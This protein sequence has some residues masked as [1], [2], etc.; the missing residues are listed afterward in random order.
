MKPKNDL[1]AESVDV[2]TIAPEEL[3][4][5]VEDESA[6][7]INSFLRNKKATM[8]VINEKIDFTT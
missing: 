8:K 1:A 6:D 3:Y 5:Y 7:T 2:A 4:K